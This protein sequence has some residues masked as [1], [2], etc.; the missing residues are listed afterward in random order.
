MIQEKSLAK[1]LVGGYYTEKNQKTLII[2]TF[3]LP[4]LT[5][6]VVEDIIIDCARLPVLDLYEARA[7]GGAAILHRLNG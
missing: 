6:A 7:F 2:D 4:Y 1:V 3:I 5:A